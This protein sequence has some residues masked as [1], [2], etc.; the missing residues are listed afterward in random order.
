MFLTYVKESQEHKN[1]KLICDLQYDM[2][3]FIFD[4]LFQQI[5]FEWVILGA[6]PDLVPLPVSDP[7]YIQ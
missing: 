4:R 5:F 1:N 3:N 2:L 7:D 6:P